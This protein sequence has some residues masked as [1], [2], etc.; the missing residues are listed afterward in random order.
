MAPKNPPLV[1]GVSPKEGPPG[2]RITIRGENLGL[3][4]RDLVGLKICG[5]DCTLLAEWKSPSKIVARTGA[6]KGKG[7]IIVV[8]KSGGKGSCTVGFR[9]YFLQIG[10]LQESAVWIDESQTVRANLDHGRTATAAPLKEEEDPLGISDEGDKVKMTEEELLELFPEASGNMSL[11]N[12]SPGWYLLEN[13]QNASFEDLKAGL[14]YMKRKAAQR[15]EGPITVVRSNLTAILDCLD[16]LTETYKK[17][18]ADDIRVNSM[19]SYAVL[20]MQ[21][22]SCA[23]GLFQEVLGRKDKADSTRNALNVLTKFR[24]LFHLPLNMERNIQKGDYNMVI[25]DFEKAKS[26]FVE[27]DVKVFKKVYKEVERRINNFRDMLHKRLLDTNNTLD[28]QKKLIGYLTSLECQGDPAWECLESQQNHIIELLEDCR[29]DHVEAEK[30]A[31]QTDAISAKNSSQS[32]TLRRK[33]VSTSPGLIFLSSA[34]PEFNA[35]NWRDRTPQKVMFVEDLTD[36]MLENFP[37]FWKLGQ[38][39]FSGEFNRTREVSEKGFKS[40]TSKHGK[41]KQ[42]IAE[43]VGLFANFVRAA[44]LPESLENLPDSE[45]LKFGVWPAAS[46]SVVQGTWLPH[47]VRTIRS[48]VSTLASLDLTAESL[49]ILQDLAFDLRTNCMFTLLKQ[50]IADVKGLY[51]KQTWSVETDDECGGTTQLP[52]LFENIVSETVQHLHEVVVLN[53]PG[54]PEVYFSQRPIQKEATLLCTSLLQAFSSCLEQLA[55]SPPSSKHAESN[56]GH[57]SKQIAERQMEMEDDEDNLPSLDKRLIIMLSDCNH[58]QE[59]VI[60]RIIDNLN[61]HGYVEM[62]KA[63]K[64]AQNTYA[65]LDKKLFESYVEQKSDPIIGAME[66]SMYRGRFSWKT[67]PPPTGVRNYLKENLMSMIE[68]HA[69]VFSISPMFVSR[70]M[71]KVTEAVVEEVTRLIHCVDSFGAHGAVQACLDLRALQETVAV[72][73]SARTDSSFKEAFQRIPSL[74]NEGNQLLENLLTEFK[75]GMKFQLM[76]FRNIGVDNRTSKRDHSSC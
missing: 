53:K 56:N 63:A 29:D 68:V 75:S 25:N 71:S 50:A 58:A 8:T 72:Y 20:L 10:P 49:N 19:D 17:F 45:R 65:E 55:F 69:E 14:T 47:C 24:F 7:D 52:A 61:R 15:S 76:C 43:L 41:L 42:M 70:V 54:E 16:S 27:T 32:N 59:V 1:T 35:S 22:K 39:Y 64:A 73:A 28:E 31:I 2:T 37:D 62:N 3:D 30:S 11:E 51:N 13:H 18:G 38:A 26:L 60:P 9:G 4:A 66:P 48:C 5:I 21:A 44:F 23:D 40:D 12:F 6:G 34:R 46:K 33:P 57:A 67:C 36:I 74:S